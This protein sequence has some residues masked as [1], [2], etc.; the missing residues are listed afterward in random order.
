MFSLQ[1]SSTPADLPARSTHMPLTISRVDKQRYSRE[2]KPASRTNSFYIQLLR[3][4]APNPI[5]FFALEKNKT[6]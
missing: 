1:S 4:P 2:E 6:G 3:S 5:F